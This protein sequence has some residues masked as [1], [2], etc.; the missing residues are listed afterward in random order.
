MNLS[1][2]LTVSY[3]DTWL[4]DVNA[5]W[6]LIVAR[7]A[8]DAAGVGS[9]EQVRSLHALV[10]QLCVQTDAEQW[11][12]VVAAVYTGLVEAGANRVYETL[13]DDLWQALS[14][15][16]GRWDIAARLWLIRQWTEETLRAV[17][18]AIDDRDPAAAHEAIAIHLRGVVS[19]LDT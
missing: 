14:E 10:A 7:A 19:T 8:E 4:Q 16:G 3:P 2:S 9:P 13:T 17:V 12:S 1:D 18:R 5:A 15:A 6:M 11:E